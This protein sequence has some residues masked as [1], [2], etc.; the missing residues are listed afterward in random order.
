MVAR[1]GFFGGPKHTIGDINGIYYNLLSSTLSRGLM[2]TEESIFSIM[3]Y[4]HADL[5]DYFE[6]ESN[7]LFGKFFEEL[8]NDTLERKNK[9]GFLPINDD[10]NPDNA[11]LYVITFNSPKQFETLIES[12]IQ[13]D[14]DFLD[15]P[16]KFLLNNSSDLSTTE[17]YTEL[18]EKYGFE[19][20]KKD[21]LGICGGRQWVAEHSEENGF[22]F[23]FF[24]E[25]DM[26]FYPQ[27]EMCVE[28]DL[29]DMFQTYTE[30]Q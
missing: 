24:F 22:D 11:A 25:D 18:C 17:R 26:F 12:M 30:I 16:K 8:K 29:I 7:G 1:G 13:Y 6:I 19:H 27:K 20:I 28:M 3:C 14:K 9:Q 10:L 4:K 21:N 5:I 15:K 23:H 2:G